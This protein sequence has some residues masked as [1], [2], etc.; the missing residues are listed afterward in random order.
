MWTICRREFVRTIGVV[1]R[2]L[3]GVF[4]PVTVRRRGDGADGRAGGGAIVISNWLMIAP[5]P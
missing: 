5:C 2:P 1:L 4:V 3:A